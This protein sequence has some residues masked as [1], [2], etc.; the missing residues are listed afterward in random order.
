MTGRWV[1]GRTF[2]RM[3]LC[4]G[5]KITEKISTPTMTKQ[6]FA[7]LSL[8]KTI[9]LHKK[10]VQRRVKETINKGQRNLLIFFASDL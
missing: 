2:V 9:G 4:I 6:I 10:D 5:L 7:C 3:Y 8:A 1:E